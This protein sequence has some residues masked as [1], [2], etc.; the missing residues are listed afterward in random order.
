MQ[1]QQDHFNRM[2]DAERGEIE[3]MEA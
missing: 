1:A 2:N 3:R